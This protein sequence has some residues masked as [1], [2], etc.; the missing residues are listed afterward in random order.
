VSVQHVTLA[1]GRW[2][3]LPF[4][5]QMAHIGG[6]A[7]RALNW[8][9]RGHEGNSVLAYERA[10]EL[11]DLTLDDPRNLPRAR[12][13]T[14]LRESL[15]DFFQ[16]PNQFGSSDTLIRKYFGAFAYAARRNH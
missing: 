4:L 7:E 5:E 9:R 1:A 12:E 3:S 10:L 2:R 8:K 16:G 6:E 11:L 13:L 15:V 14:R